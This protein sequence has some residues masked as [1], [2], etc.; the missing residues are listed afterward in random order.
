MFQLAFVAVFLHL[1]APLFEAGI[2][3]QLI[4]SFETGI[5]RWTRRHGAIIG[6]WALKAFGLAF[7]RAR[8]RGLGGIEGTDLEGVFAR[9]N[10]QHRDGT[11]Y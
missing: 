2:S 9:A 1:P 8:L 7:R 5:R 3:E 10:K 11:A 6:T 4:D